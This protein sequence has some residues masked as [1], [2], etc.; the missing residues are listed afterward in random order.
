MDKSSKRFFVNY[1]IFILENGCKYF[2]AH[3]VGYH[4]PRRSH[5]MLVPNFCVQED[6]ESIRTTYFSSHGLMRESADVTEHLY[7]P[8][9]HDVIW[10]SMSMKV[11]EREKS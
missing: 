1:S 7:P 10:L 6:I 8:K 2:L 3:L 4:T 11:F 5:K 9:A